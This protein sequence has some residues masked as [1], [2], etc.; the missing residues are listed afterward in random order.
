MN[1][2]ISTIEVVI[3]NNTE[4]PMDNRKSNQLEHDRCVTRSQHGQRLLI[5]NGTGPG[6]HRESA[7]SVKMTHT[8]Q[9][10]YANL[11]NLVK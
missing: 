1:T 8:P 4:E 7:S 11:S 2:Y 9:M 5:Q 3:S 6:V 10:F